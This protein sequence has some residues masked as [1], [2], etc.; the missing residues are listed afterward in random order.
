MRNVKRA[1]LSLARV[2]N[3]IIE[4]KNISLRNVDVLPHSA[5][6]STR[7]QKTWLLIL[8][9]PLSVVANLKYESLRPQNP[10][11]KFPLLK[12]VRIVISVF[13]FAY[14]V[15]RKIVRRLI[16]ILNYF[17]FVCATRK[18]KKNSKDLKIII[19]LLLS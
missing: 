1:T 10:R 7:V 18:M 12:F 14:Y 5:L 17:T 11:T 15:V 8:I 9:S 16:N 6:N 3:A 13:H 19:Y 2:I 4:Y